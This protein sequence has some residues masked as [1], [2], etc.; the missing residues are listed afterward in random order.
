LDYDHEEEDG[1][2]KVTFDAR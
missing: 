1:R 2:T